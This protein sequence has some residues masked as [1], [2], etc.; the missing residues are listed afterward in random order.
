MHTVPRAGVAWRGTK[1]EQE[2]FRDKGEK[3]NSEEKKQ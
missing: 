1:S 3:K 2:I